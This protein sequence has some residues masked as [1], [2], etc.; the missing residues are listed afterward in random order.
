MLV[1]TLIISLTSAEEKKLKACASAQGIDPSDYAHLL[2]GRGLESRPATGADAIA[3]W[4]NEGVFGTFADRP[5]SPEFA[6]MLR[7]EA[8][9]RR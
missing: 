6:K 4:E 7:E 1:T 2:I 5:D 8:E 9:K 3:F